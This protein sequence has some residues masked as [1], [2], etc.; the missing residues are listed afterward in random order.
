MSKHIVIGKAD[1]PVHLLGE[2]GNRHGLIAGATGTGKTVTLMTIAEG[3]SRMGTPVFVADVKG[4]M[5][6]LAKAGEQKKKIVERV[7]EIGIDN[8]EFAPNPVTLWDLWGKRG[9]PVRTTIDEVGPT[10]MGRM[11][12]LSDVQEGV[13]E[14][15]F[16]YARKN[17]IH[18]NTLDDLRELMVRVSENRSEVSRHFGLVSDSSIGAIQRNLLQME[19]D[20]INNFFG[21]P[22]F[23][24]NDLMRKD[25]NRHGY[26][27][28][29][30]AESLILKPRIYSTFLLWLLTTLFEKLPEVGDVEKPKLVFFF[31]EAHLLFDDCPSALLQRIEQ[32]ADAVDVGAAFELDERPFPVA[33]DGLSGHALLGRE[34]QRDGAELRDV[35]QHLVAGERDGLRI[36]SVLAG[37]PEFILVEAPD[38]VDHARGR[39]RPRLET[40]ANLAQRIDAVADLERDAAPD[41]LLE[42]LDGRRRDRARKTCRAV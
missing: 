10:L 23:E 22:A 4:D 3:F 37:Q 19:S 35:G 30:S 39:L 40:V 25:K 32:V 38:P 20:G 29:L 34:I 14:V 33:L 28:I 26:I 2:Y 41:V 31:D 8:F 11:L 13:L 15:S 7:N 16:H 17:G 1:R 24:F 21:R 27:N 6:G 12:E 42:I 36:Q 9:V 18:L 5:S